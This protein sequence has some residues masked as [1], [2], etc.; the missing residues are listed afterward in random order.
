[1]E[2]L[3]EKVP[4]VPFQILLHGA[5]VVGYT[6]CADNVVYKFCKQAQVIGSGVFRVFNLLNYLDNLK[7]GIDA[8]GAA[9]G[10]GEGT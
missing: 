2:K 4:D 6:T 7:L 10:F 9:R 8:E 1:M 3:C 5:N